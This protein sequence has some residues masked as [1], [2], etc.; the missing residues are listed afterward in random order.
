MRRRDFITA[1]GG[2]AIAWPLV[3][4]AQAERVRSV[5][6]LL[7]TSEEDA[8]GQARVALLRQGLN[9]LGRVEGRNIHFDNR[10]ARGDAA[11]AKAGAAALVNQKPDVIV[12]NSTLSLAATNSE[13]TTIPIVFVVVGD[14]IGQGFV[15]SLAHPVLRRPVE[16][17]RAD[18]TWRAGT[19]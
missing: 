16:P 19:F 9:E 17:A 15:S 4:R 6:V 8:E 18:R 11:R 2:S 14:P 7:S 3:A 12:A 10:W 13:T 1:I 5:G